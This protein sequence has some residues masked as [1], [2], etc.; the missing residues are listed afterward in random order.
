LISGLSVPSR[1]DGVPMVVR[2]SRC[3]N[4][5]GMKGTKDKKDAEGIEASVRPELNVNRK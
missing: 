5:K 4:R 1:F 2:L 3:L